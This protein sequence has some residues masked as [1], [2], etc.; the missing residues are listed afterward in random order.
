M[1]TLI[2][3]RIKIL[4]FWWRHMAPPATYVAVKKNQKLLQLKS[5]RNI[6]FEK[7]IIEIIIELISTVQ[8]LVMWVKRLLLVGETEGETTGK[9]VEYLILNVGLP[10]IWKANSIKRFE[11]SCVAPSSER[12]ITIIVLFLSDGRPTLDTYQTLHF[13]FR[14]GGRCSEAVTS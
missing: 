9:W 3:F 12:N 6:P 1:T 4:E 11:R 10:P 2:G 5:N 14:I 8:Y 7:A 13:V